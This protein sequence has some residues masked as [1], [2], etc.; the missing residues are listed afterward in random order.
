MRIVLGRNTK[1]FAML[2]TTSIRPFSA[3]RL[4]QL[5]GLLQWTARPS[6]E[7][8]IFLS[9]HYE[10]LQR[11][12]PPN[13]F[14]S[15]CGNLSFSPASIMS[16]PCHH[17][18]KHPIF[19]RVVRIAVAWTPLQIQCSRQ[20]VTFAQLPSGIVLLRATRLSAL[21]HPF[22]QSSLVSRFWAR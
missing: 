1:I 9:S 12:N 16:P 8:G 15:K 19:Q 7:I 3:R 6:L 20:T 21:E 4:Q 11:S 2:T 22:S 18:G 10:L 17:S 13:T 14:P 5:L